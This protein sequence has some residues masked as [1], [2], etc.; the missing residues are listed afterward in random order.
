V[1]LGHEVPGTG[2]AHRFDEKLAVGAYRLKAMMLD[3]NGL[4]S[5]KSADQRCKS[6]TSDVDDIGSA[7]EL[8]KT[9][10]SRPAD[11]TEGE[12]VVIE[13]ARWSL[14]DDGNC[15]LPRAVRS[16][17]LRESAGK[18]QHNRFHAADTRHKE[19]RI[20]QQLHREDFCG[21]AAFCGPRERGADLRE[22]LPARNV[23]TRI[24]S[25]AAETFFSGDDERMC[26][27]Y[28]WTGAAKPA[29]SVAVLLRIDASAWMFP[30]G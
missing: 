13:V 14:R 18:A 15:D 21:A 5:K 25:M 8:A 28:G 3:D 26:R 30:Q 7:D 9:R 24:A 11:D 27:L 19:V 1:T 16:T 10:E 29:R 22:H 12:R 17:K 4:T 2:H 20:D 23:A 6:G